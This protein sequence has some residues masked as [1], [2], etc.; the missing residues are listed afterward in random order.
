MIERLCLVSLKAAFRRCSLKRLFSTILENSQKAT[1]IRVS[2]SI[3]LQHVTRPPFFT[4]YLP[5]AASDN[6]A[7]RPLSTIYLEFDWKSQRRIMPLLIKN[8]DR[9]S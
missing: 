3:K 8:V 9:I 2:F 5:A 1:C 4:G 6:V 7:Y